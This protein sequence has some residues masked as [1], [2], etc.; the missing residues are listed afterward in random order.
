MSCAVVSSLDNVIDTFN[1]A[2]AGL[3]VTVY[4]VVQIYPWFKFYLPIVL[5]YGDV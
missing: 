2:F 1:A 4:I 5:G 3:Q